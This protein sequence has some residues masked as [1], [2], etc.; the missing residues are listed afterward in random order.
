MNKRIAP[1]AR[2]AFGDSAAVAFIAPKMSRAERA[3]V[4]EKF[5][6]T[7]ATL[8][9]SDDEIR[10][11]YRL[12]ELTAAELAPLLTHEDGNVRRLASGQFFGRCTLEERE[13][14]RAAS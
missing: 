13:A 8:N 9:A 1:I 6:E 12:R 3:V 11:S 7:F 14:A 10:E 2:P 4:Q 5:A